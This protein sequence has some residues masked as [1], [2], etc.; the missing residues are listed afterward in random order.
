[1]STPEPDATPPIPQPEPARLHIRAELPPGARLEVTVRLE[2]SPGGEGMERKLE[3]TNPSDSPALV[4]EDGAVHPLPTPRQT[5]A[6]RLRTWL[7]R[8]ASRLPANPAAW[9][10]GLALAAYLITRLIGLES[11]PIYFFTDEAVQTVLASDL[12]DNH[13]KSYDDEVLPTF[14]V[15]GGQYNLGVSVYAQVL[16]AL[17]LPRSVF[18]TRGVSVF[19]SLIAALAVGFTLRRVF[20]SQLG[21]AAVLLLSIT[22]AWFL[23]SRTAFETAMAVSFFAGFIYCYARY[24]QG[25]PRFLYGAAGFGALAFYSYSPAQLVVAFSVLLLAIS[26][27]RY[28][29]Q[30]RRVVLRVLG[31]GLLLG[32]PYVRFLINHPGENLRHLEILDS[33]WVRNI[34]LGEKLGTWFRE[35]LEG[36]NL[37]YWYLPNEADLERHRMLGYGNI[38]RHTLPFLL[39]GLGVAFARFRRSEYRMLILLTLAAPAGAALAQMGITRGLFMVI[40]AALLTA[41]GLTETVEW[42]ARRKI[43]RAVLAGFLL[44]ALLGT[45]I[46]MLT[47]ALRNGPLWYRNYGLGGMQWG[48]RQLFAQAKIYLQENPDTNMMI[49]PAW[50]NGTDV[51]AR[52]FVRDPLPFHMGSVL[53]HVDNYLPLDENNLFV[54]IPDEYDQVVKS[55]KFASVDVKKTILHPDGKPG[56]YFVQLEYSQEARRIFAEEAEARKALQVEGVVLPNQDLITVKYS[57]LDMGE[58]KNVFDGDDATLARTLEANPFQVEVNFPAPLEMQEVLVLV[59]GTDTR[60]TL[61][62]FAPAATEPLTLTE[63]MGESVDVK[64]I[65]FSFDA[66]LV[67]RMKLDVFSVRDGEPAHVH[68]WEVKW[69]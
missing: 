28:H 47:D 19:I 29:W 2:T 11:F 38:L 34:P 14:F 44:V 61:Q 18:V 56:F 10:M 45:N 8:A 65:A 31:L 59:G 6:D 1:M 42:L 17:F 57:M 13:L 43:S 35:Y 67:E 22:P 37:F 30:N 60:V 36:L 53:G 20:H 12:L 54:M 3:F 32:L 46:Y 69:K 64:T 48:G 16:P 23:H 51:I 58:I 9:L 7:K 52:F 63:Q 5:L 21:W 27:A 25:E 49:S 68:L 24:R 26:D 40:P 66:Q 33:Y 62:L 39:V 4:E 15:N 55:G 41:V 50:A